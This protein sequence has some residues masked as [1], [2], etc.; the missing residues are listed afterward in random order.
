MLKRK[1]FLSYLLFGIVLFLSVPK[2]KSQNFVIDSIAVPAVAYSC[3]NTVVTVYT[4]L[5]CINY[6]HTGDADSVNGT[7]IGLKISRTYSSVCFGAITYPTH[8]FNLGI[9]PPGTYTITA[10]ANY[11]GIG[12][13]S[14]SSKTLV[15]TDCC[16]S[17]AFTADFD[18]SD[19]AVCE[20][21]SVFCTNTST[22]SAV[23]YKW[24]VNGVYAAN[25]TNFATQFTAI[26]MHNIQL[27]A[28]SGG[29]KRI[30]TREISVSE[31]PLLNLG[32]DKSM[33]VGNSVT[34]NAGPGWDSLHWSTAETSQY[35]N[36]T[37]SGYISLVARDTSHCALHYD[38]LHVAFKPTPLVSFGNDTTLCEG[39]KLL[40][41]ASNPGATYLWQDNSIGALYEVTQAGKYWVRAKYTN[42]CFAS[43]TILVGYVICTGIGGQGDPASP[44]VLPNPFSDFIT[45]AGD[46]GKVLKNVTIYNPSGA[47]VYFAETLPANSSIDVS[48]LS[49]GAYVLYLQDDGALKI[50]KL[51]RTAK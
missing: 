49:P 48:N 2:V 39:E 8:T 9:L 5:G 37:D 15:V 16:P 24:N 44:K 42:G 28:D 50:F 7:S 23:T 25:T 19:T 27:L 22:G 47:R 38:T 36:V 6:T 29:C 21:D 1:F 20:N 34:L 13:A 18:I 10:T 12:V 51:V 4:Y 45:I 14:T 3:S 35:I 11:A 41:N 26:G 17:A 43:D 40:L 30:K 32:A 31:L 46:E 33:C